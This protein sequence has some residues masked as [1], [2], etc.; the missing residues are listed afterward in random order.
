MLKEV[1]ISEA[2][3][4]AQDGADVTVLIS[5]G[6]GR[7]G[8]ELLRIPLQ[9]LLEA[10]VFL[11]DQEAPEP[12]QNAPEPEP[13]PTAPKRKQI[14]TGKILALHNAGWSNVKIADEMRLHPITVGK[15]VKALTAAEN[16]E[17]KSL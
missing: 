1:T 17:E 6:G 11:T 7:E 2:L 9:E 5:K 12:E 10:C 4:A 8:R 14:D 16:K 13:K 15:Y 3:Q